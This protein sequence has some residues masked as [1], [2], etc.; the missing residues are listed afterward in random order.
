M[1]KTRL[2]GSTVCPSKV[3]GKEEVHFYQVSLSTY[4]T[5]TFFVFF[6]SLLAIQPTKHL[7]CLTFI[8]KKHHKTSLFSL[9][10]NNLCQTRRADETLV[11]YTDLPRFFRSTLLI[12]VIIK[13]IVIVSATEAVFIYR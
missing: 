1:S 5:I 10:L 3:Q 2:F 8:N 6:A 4:Q 11:L 9:A 13:K 12:T 7:S